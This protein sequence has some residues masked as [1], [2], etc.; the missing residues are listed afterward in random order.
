MF[1]TLRGFIGGLLA[2]TGSRHF[3]DND[4]RL[5]A[6]ALLIH[7]ADADGDLEAQEKRRLRQIVSE[8]FGLDAGAAARLVAEATASGHAEVGVNHFV[9]TLKRVLE[10]DGR[11]KLV[12]M[13]WDMV[14]ADGAARETEDSIVWRIAAMLGIAE[15]DM[16]T[17]RRSRAPDHW[18]GSKT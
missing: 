12:E 8:R 11:L 18:P 3:D 13:M 5:A 16:E 10:E 15:K 7:V 2:Q 9:N 14:Y 6:T 4:H 1:D 17:L